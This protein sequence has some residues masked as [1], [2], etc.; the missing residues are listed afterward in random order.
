[1][2]ARRNE[3]YF[4]KLG[5]NILKNATQLSLGSMTIPDKNLSAYLK[6]TN[7]QPLFLHGDAKET[8]LSFPNSSVDM[9]MTS[10][11]YWMQREYIK[12]GIGFEKSFEEYVASLLEVFIQVHRVLKPEGSFWL[13][14]GDKYLKKNLLGM[15]WRV[16]IKLMDTQ[17][18]ILRNDIIWHKIKGAPD[19]SKDR[20]RTIH[21]HVFHFVKQRKGYYYD[22][23]LIRNHP[24]K[25]KIK[26]GAIISAT[27]V[28]GVR[29]KQQIER[30]EELSTE[31]KIVALQ[32]L[33]NMLMSM[34]VGKVTDFRMIIRGQ[35]RATHS[36]SI[37]VSGRA[38]E[39]NDN[40]FYF[41]RYHPKGAKPSDVWEILPEDTQKRKIHFAPY[42]EELCRI[43]ILATCPLKGIVLDPFCGVG[44]TMLAAGHLGRRSIGIDLGNKYLEIARERCLEIF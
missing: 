15:P 26:N 35:Q 8:L 13:N 40:G 5:F 7:L 22:V 34:S 4:V 39:L 38:K 31:E 1:M 29:Y 25:T 3:N 11:P 18:W 41:L 37:K 24:K 27:G 32:A 10:P 12:D 19:N 23:D 14:L 30:S 16:A 2:Q 6:G 42:P 17:G 43:P 36:N 9:C 28:T 33:N 44:T 21:E 20:L